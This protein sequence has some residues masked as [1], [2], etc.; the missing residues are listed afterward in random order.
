M[1][2]RAE[3]VLVGAVAAVGVLHT[4]V[5]DHWVPI[6]LVARQRGWTRREVTRAAL[7]AG[8]GHT[9]STLAIGLV[10]WLAGAAFATRFGS[11]V[12]TLSSIALI[13]FGM[14]VVF[15]S[16]RELRG[17][18]HGH[19]H[20]YER[21]HDL[22]ADDPARSARTDPHA[23]DFGAGHEH[24]HDLGRHHH[25]DHDRDHDHHHHHEDDRLYV[26]SSAGAAVLTRHAHAHRHVGSAVHVH[27]H[28]HG[29]ETWHATTAETPSD[30]PMHEHGHKR[31]H[32]TA[33][34]FILGSSPMVEGIPAFFSA[35]K[36][37]FGLIAV[38]ATFFA[39]AT[40]LTYVVLCVASVAGLRRISFGPIERYGEAF[41][42]AVIALVG[43]VFM[44][45]PIL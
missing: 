32:R 3:V 34:L 35:A 22:D 19:A 43:L 17:G 24:A 42:G 2:D 13:A 29:P 31:E 41:S 6:T 16:L 10:V 18:G 27:L 38:M 45:F 8:A 39:C 1:V 28:D 14:W 9:I 23:Y 30:P 26:P 21:V 11:A 15:S 20:R 36:F 40:M 33:L 44:V 7:I 25:D 5:P 37:G 4:I 12:S